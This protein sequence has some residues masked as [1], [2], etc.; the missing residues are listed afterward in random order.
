[1]YTKPN[2]AKQS[3]AD[4]KVPVSFPLAIERSRRSYIQPE[5]LEQTSINV[6]TQTTARKL[7]LSGFPIG[8]M[9]HQQCPFSAPPPSQS[10]HSIHVGCPNCSLRYCLC[11]TN[12]KAIVQK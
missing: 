12:R 6:I 5:Q 1:M 3:R 4:P 11:T 7:T 2:E 9:A 10:C 8:K